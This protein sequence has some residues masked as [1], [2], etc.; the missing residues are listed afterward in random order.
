MYSGQTSFIRDVQPDSFQSFYLALP[1]PPLLWLKTFLNILM[2][3]LISSNSLW[4]HLIVSY[5]AIQPQTTELLFSRPCVLRPPPLVGVALISWQTRNLESA[6]KEVVN[7]TVCQLS[8][9]NA[10]RVY[11]SDNFRKSVLT[12]MS[13]SRQKEA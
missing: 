2:N 8:P 3:Q 5:I 1:L 10:S 6:P 4:L 12:I 9:S 13:Q 7:M 11:Y